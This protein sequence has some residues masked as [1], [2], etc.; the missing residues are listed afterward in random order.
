MLVAESQLLLQAVSSLHTPYHVLA[1]PADS[2][3]EVDSSNM[4]T[5]SDRTPEPGA[6]LVM[7]SA[8]AK[9]RG[10]GMA[11]VDLSVGSSDLQPPPEAL[12][13]IKVISV[14]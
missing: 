4:K 9:A 7:D 13:A 3:P 8:K 11:L 14:E 12:E 2:K 6:F 5:R 10:A 1:L